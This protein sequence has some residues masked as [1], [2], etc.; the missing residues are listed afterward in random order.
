[1]PSSLD[2][3]ARA[4]AV[5]QDFGAEAL[6]LNHRLV[7]ANPAD[8]GS[9]TRLARCYLQAGRLDEAE[10]EYREALRLNPHN[11]IASGGLEAIEQQR[12]QGEVAA[13]RVRVARPG[14]VRREGA[15]RPRESSLSP[16]PEPVPQT[17]TG[18]GPGDF[19]ELAACRRSLVQA[20][21]APRVRDLIRRVNALAS[22]VEMA[23]IREPGRRQLFRVGRADVHPGDAHWYVFN[24]GGRWEPQC[25][26]GMYGGQ[27]VGDWVRVG[28]G[29]N[30]ADEGADPDRAAGVMKVRQH[31]RR[32]QEILASPRRSLFLGWMVKE[33]ARLQ[34]NEGG[35]RLDIRE[36]SQAASLIAE[37]DPERT[38]WIFFG[39]WLRLEDADE[40]AILLDPVSLVRTIDRVFTGLVPLWRAL[41][42]I[43]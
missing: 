17:F 39:K 16:S 19:A 36:P 37:C 23:G 34:Y 8:A 18:L 24:L 32:F 40:A 43:G 21:F 26:I 4:L 20:R 41:H 12:A 31:F 11:R 30:L 5:A 7:V 9:R 6:D 42:E 38:G 2:D 15:T 3:R 13:K 14:R 28:L 22:S 27:P 35:P 1:M 25:N 10:A 29:F 33:N